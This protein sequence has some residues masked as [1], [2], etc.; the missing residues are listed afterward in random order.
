MRV[1]AFE[2]HPDDVEHFCAGT[3]AKYAD[4]GHQVAIV[5]MTDGG[6]GSPDPMVQVVR[7]ADAAAV[8]AA[9]IFHFGE[10]TVGDAKRHLKRHGIP[11]SL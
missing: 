11:V 4:R 9:S 3:L 7:E 10:F 8:L 5:C 1:M 2:A 6:C